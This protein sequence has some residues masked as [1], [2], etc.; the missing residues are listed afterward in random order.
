M[1]LSISKILSFLGPK[2]NYSK[3]SWIISGLS[4]SI[5]ILCLAGLLFWQVKEESKTYSSAN[6]ISI[7]IPFNS[8]SNK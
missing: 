1:N 2:E 6:A 8:A 4:I 5:I 7:Q 3:I